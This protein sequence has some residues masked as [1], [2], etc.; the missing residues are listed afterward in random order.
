[1]KNNNYSW[2]STRSISL[3]EQFFRKT[4]VSTLCAFTIIALFHVLAWPHIKGAIASAK[5]TEF[6]MLVGVYKQ[7]LTAFHAERGYWPETKDLNVRVANRFQEIAEVPV[8]VESVNNGMSS[9]KFAED[10]S[11]L[12][13]GK[14]LH[15]RPEL[16]SVSTV[17]WQCAS[18]DKVSD[19]QTLLS[20]QFEAFRFLCQWETGSHKNK[21]DAS[22]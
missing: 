16:T 19:H 22:E 21:D 14:V 13:S 12:F 11:S 3:S 1:M 7:D 6:F 17:R 15:Y 20:Q 5:L 8:T 9:F 2:L 18:G 10:E 4:L